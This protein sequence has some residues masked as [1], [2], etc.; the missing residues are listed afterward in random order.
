MEDEGQIQ[1]SR[2]R[3]PNLE[4]NGTF[5]SQGLAYCTWMVNGVFTVDASSLY[6]RRFQQYA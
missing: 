1:E 4:R 2:E 3:V 5:W 6:R